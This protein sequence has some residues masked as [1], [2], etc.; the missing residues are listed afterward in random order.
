MHPDEL[1]DDLDSLGCSYVVA[2][3]HQHHWLWL[4]NLVVCLALEVEHDIISAIVPVECLLTPFVPEHPFNLSN[5]V[6]KLFAL[7]KYVE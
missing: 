6:V 2:G 3:V 4:E 5:R 7:T 1:I